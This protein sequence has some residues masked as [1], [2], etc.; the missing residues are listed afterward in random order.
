MLKLAETPY[1]AKA[2]AGDPHEIS[3]LIELYR[4]EPQ[5]YSSDTVI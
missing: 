4:C 1:P 2:R 5:L 3:H